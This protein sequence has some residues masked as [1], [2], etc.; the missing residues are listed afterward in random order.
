MTASSRP[1][2]PAAPR[3]STTGIV[4]LLLVAAG[5]L[6][7]FAAKPRRPAP[8]PE[9]GNVLLD[10]TLDLAAGGE[11]GVSRRLR[12]KNPAVLDVAVDPWWGGTPL[13][14]SL[15]PPQAPEEAPGDLPDPASPATMRWTADSKTPRKTFP[16][17]APGLYVLHVTSGA[18]LK[19]GGAWVTVRALPPR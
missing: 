1:A 9:P 5:A 14:F 10:E 11:G 6:G 4:V 16:T 12:L 17:M 3:A 15:G 18:P 7:W 13:E 2:T 19:S 8:R